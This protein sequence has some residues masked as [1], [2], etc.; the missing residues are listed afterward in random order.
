[1]IVRLHPPCGP[2]IQFD[3]LL[4]KEEERQWRK[5]RSAACRWT[6][7]RRSR[8]SMKARPTT[9]VVP[10]AKPR[11]TRTQPNTLANR[12]VAAVIAA[13]GDTSILLAA[14]GGGR[15]W[16]IGWH[17]WPFTAPGRPPR[18]AAHYASEDTLR[19]T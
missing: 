19:G 14:R 7:R 8:A 3:N 16:D 4:S 15:P 12:R 6:R 17:L 5:T 1:M 11:S 13:A 18:P 2:T 9:S 10:D